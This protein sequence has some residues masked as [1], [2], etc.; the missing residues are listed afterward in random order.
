MKTNF[1]K[2][3]EDRILWIRLNAE[4]QIDW[5]KGLTYFDT[6][7][8]RNMLTQQALHPRSMDE[9]MRIAKN[10]LEYDE[11]N[12]ELRFTLEEYLILNNDQLEEIRSKKH[13]EWCRK[14]ESL[15]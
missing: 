8:G 15:K 2:S 7:T 9:A 5:E 11:E 1:F 10:Q 14:F 13:E 12:G 4:H 3:D 6:K